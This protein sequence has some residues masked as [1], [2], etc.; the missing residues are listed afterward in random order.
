[1]FDVEFAHQ[2]KTFGRLKEL[3]LDDLNVAIGENNTAA[4]V[5]GPAEIR[6]QADKLA[7][8]DGLSPK[9]LDRQILQKE[10]RKAADFGPIDQRPRAG[11][12]VIT[13]PS[14]DDINFDIKHPN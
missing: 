12:V 13:I 6:L 7:P 10:M 14:S 4:A 9:E 5:M 1:R 11:E 8:Y 2:G 3:N